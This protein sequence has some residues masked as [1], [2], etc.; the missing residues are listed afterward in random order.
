MRHCDRGLY[1]RR[2]V[3]WIMGS[4]ERLSLTS[5]RQS[6]AGSWG[7]AHAVPTS[8]V[9]AGFEPITVDNR[10]V[11][12]QEWL[13]EA[14]TMWGIA[15]LVIVVTAVG[16]DSDVTAW[17]YRHRRCACRRAPACPR[18]TGPPTV[19]EHLGPDR[20][21]SVVL[22]VDGTKNKARSPGK[23]LIRSCQVLDHTAPQC[24]HP[25]IR[26]PAGRSFM[27]LRLGPCHQRRTRMGHSG[28]VAPARCAP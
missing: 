11:M 17:V 15:A 28:P 25:Y 1:P 9:I 13:V 6:Q 16:G 18:R 19:E 8:Q 14:V 24:G 2:R 10:R 12:L 27:P 23:P 5:L 20:M 4:W 26:L 7:V 3:C 22:A 21:H